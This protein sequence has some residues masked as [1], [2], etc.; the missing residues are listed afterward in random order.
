MKILV[1]GA[2]ATGGFFGGRLVEAGAELAFLV[3]ERRR[4]Q[5]RREGL[6]IEGHAGVTTV[7][8]DARLEGEISEGFDLVLLTCKAYDL[9]SAIAAIRPLV[10]SATVILPLLNGI[11]HIDVLNAQFGHERVLGGTARIQATVTADGVV[12]QL[13][14]WQTITFGEQ[15]GSRSP[16]VVAL[17]SLLDKTGVE[18]RLSA[19]IMRDMWLKMVHLATVAATT[20]LMRANIGE[21]VRTADGSALLKAFFDA[22]ARIAAHAGYPPDEAFVKSYYSLFE[23]RD[24]RYEASMLRDLE[25]GGPVEADHILGYMLGKC[26]EAGLDDLLHKAAYVHVKA[27]EQCRAAN[28]LPG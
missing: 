10:G 20:C 2:G 1:L 13:N 15:D 25:K 26:R 4:E 6:R 8:V 16:R 19:H 12:R 11:A 27:Y 22:N 24:S 17:K 9:A 5:L 21:I 18:A 23:Q 3:R 28:R 7:A 14:D